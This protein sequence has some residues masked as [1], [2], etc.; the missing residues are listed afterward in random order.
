M[1]IAI[2][3]T[4]SGKDAHVDTHGARAPYYLILNKDT[5][6]SE[7]LPNPVSQ[8]E[9]RAGPQAAAFLV[10]QGVEKVVAGDFGPK[11]RTELE[12]SNIVCTEMAGSVMKVVAEL[13]AHV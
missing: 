1:K 8:T 4:S 5:G 3:V 2:A 12:G 13:S 6:S 10:S 11:F 9:R 7:T